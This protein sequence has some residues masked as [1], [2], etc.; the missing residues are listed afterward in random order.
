MRKNTFNLL[1]FCGGLAM[2][3]KSADNN[4]NNENKV[5]K[6]VNSV[7]EVAKPYID[8][9]TPYVENAVKNAAPVAKDLRSKAEPVMENIKTKAE[10]VVEEI[11]SKTEP[12]VETLKTKA[13]P[14][15][16]KA[17]KATEPAS[18]MAK[19]VTDDLSENA[20][21]KAI[22]S[23]IF[24]QYND[25]EIRSEDIL[26]KARLDYINK[27]HKLSEIHDM[28]VYI[29]PNEAKAFYVINNQDTGRI[30]F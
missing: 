16:K 19:I 4:G 17:K 11:I 25:H 5:K 14:Y 24:L 12:V 28:Q 18:R 21:K 15:L 29:K 8:K 3:Y 27:G 23:E 20:A 30:E 9:A 22:K 7:S 10:P 26:E 13:D 6:F 2:A 1:I